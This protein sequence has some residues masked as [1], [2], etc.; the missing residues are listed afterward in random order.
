MGSRLQSWDTKK[1]FT[2]METIVA[3]RGFELIIHGTE[4]KWG[5]MFNMFTGRHLESPFQLTSFFILDILRTRMKQQN[6]M[7]HLSYIKR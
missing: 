3:N 5:N 1:L 2:A 7:G 6:R 4:M